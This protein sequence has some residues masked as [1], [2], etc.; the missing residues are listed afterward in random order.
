MRKYCRVEGIVAVVLDYPIFPTLCPL[1]ISAYK[2][3]KMKIINR[4]DRRDKNI[5]ELHGELV[6]HV[7]S[8]D[9][10]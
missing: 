6:L 9:L 10:I 5:Q 3:Y 1:E 2:I 8:I 4:M 7:E